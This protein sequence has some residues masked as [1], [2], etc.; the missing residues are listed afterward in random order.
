MALEQ[1]RFEQSAHIMCLDK[2]SRL[3]TI[4]VFSGI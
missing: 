2:E 3:I 4:Y 1:S